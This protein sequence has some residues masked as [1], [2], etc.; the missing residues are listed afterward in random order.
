MVYFQL[1]IFNQLAKHVINL[2]WDQKEAL[3]SGKEIQ[4]V[5]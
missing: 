1:V 4:L 5:K 3:A 2:D